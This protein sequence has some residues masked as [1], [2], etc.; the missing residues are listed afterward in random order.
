MSG[1]M[2]S[3]QS[4]SMSAAARGELLQTIQNAIESEVIAELSGATVER[5][6]TKV[7]VNDDGVH[8]ILGL[9]IHNLESGKGV[10]L[11]IPVGS[12]DPEQG[13]YF[14]GIDNGEYHPYSNPEE[15]AQA[16]VSAYKGK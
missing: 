12:A 2:E 7:S 10:V 9:S 14:A 13:H 3:G 11:E 15:I 16:A 1:E 6:S 5:T 8:P 4:S